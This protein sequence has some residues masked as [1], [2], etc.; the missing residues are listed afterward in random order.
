MN[1]VQDLSRPKIVRRFT[2]EL[3]PDSDLATQTKSYQE[4]LDMEIEVQERL[5][6][7]QAYHQRPIERY[8]RET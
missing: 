4:D 3:K 5:R 8:W 6:M 1:T 7:Q 2:S